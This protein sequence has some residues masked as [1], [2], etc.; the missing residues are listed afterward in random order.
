VKIALLTRSLDRGGA[1]RQL[2]LLAGA[3][4]QRGHD[5]SVLTF[6]PGGALA[7]DLA[8][9]GVARIALEKH[10]RWDLLG[11]FSRLL[12]WL[13]RERP[14]LIYSFM[15][16]ANLTATAAQLLLPWLKI[17][18]GIRAARLDLAAYDTVSGMA[19]RLELALRHRADAIIANSAAGLTPFLDHGYPPQSAA[20][21]PNGIDTQRFARDG[22]GRERLRKEWRVADDAPLIGIVA[23]IDPQKDQATFLQAAK[24]ITL[25]RPDARFIVVGSGS[26]ALT[27]SLQ[28]MARDAGLEG[29]L[30]WAAARDDMP[31]VYSALDCLVL[32]SAFGEGF[33]NVLAEAQA[34]CTACI[35]T[36][37]GESRRAL[38]DPTRIVPPR[39][40]TALA[41]AVL[42]VLAEE[43]QDPMRGAARRA[44]MERDFSVDRLA[45]RTEAIL[46]AVTQRH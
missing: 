21:I 27:Q 26:P 35:A 8:A 24:T 10:G 34:C 41:A 28:V 23:R 31:A 29:K 2:C 43:A 36:D 20:M 22:A 14:D 12:S 40:P 16:T 37:I 9:V 30:T 44:R 3:L 33:P 38:D 5:V 6:Y 45:E 17:V 42:H 32:S 7:A 46:S 15:P 1:E 19:Y 13:R 4:K 11:F 25:Q 39:D 18:W